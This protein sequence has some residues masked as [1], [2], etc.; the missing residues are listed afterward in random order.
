MKEEL[1]KLLGTLIKLVYSDGSA[2]A[3][4]IKGKLISIGE[5][6]VSVETYNNVHIVPFSQILKVQASINEEVHHD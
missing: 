2:S 5:D 6:C 3:C 1:Q 4:V